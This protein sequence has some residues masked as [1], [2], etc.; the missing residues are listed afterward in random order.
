MIDGLTDAER[1]R[2]KGWLATVADRVEGVLREVLPPED[3]ALP[4][5]PVFACMRYATLGGGKRLRAAL[6]LAAYEVC[7]GRAR[8]RPLRAAAAMEMI[9]AYSL[10]QDDMPC[11]DNDALRR[12]KPTAHVAYGET[13]ALLAS[14]GLQ[15][16]AYE[17]LAGERV[18]PDPAAR[19]DV[20][21]LF[22]QAS[23]ARG[24]VAGQMADMAYE[25]AGAGVARAD[26]ARMDL[27]KTGLN[28]RASVLAGVILAG[29]GGGAR[30][31]LE[32]YAG[33]LGKA[34][35]IWDDVLDVTATAGELGKT[36]GKDAKAGKTTF[37]SL[38]GL[39]GA[40]V[41]AREEAL[42]ALEALGALGEAADLLRLLA[43]HTVTREA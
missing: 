43:R 14:D 24:M 20:V 32:A 3:A 1:A 39:E 34:Y 13:V 21:R 11:M 17:V 16:G 27:L 5:N 15:T 29:G 35:Q 22:A 41:A 36:P 38:L 25:K 19:L 33:H 10:I 30:A 23:G 42:R 37:V 8:E 4:E 26:L 28:I 7:G 9:H 18:H 6:T 31:A 40:K 12:G 2:L